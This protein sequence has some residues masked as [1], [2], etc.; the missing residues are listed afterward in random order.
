MS[1]HPTATPK[2]KFS[3]YDNC[4]SITT[5]KGKKTQASKVKKVAKFIFEKKGADMTILDLKTQM[6]KLVKF[7]ERTNPKV[8][9][10]R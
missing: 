10:A 4:L 8:L 1:V 2:S 3:K 9:I 5:K 6:N 7:I